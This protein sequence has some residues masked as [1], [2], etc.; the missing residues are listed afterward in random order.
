LLLRVLGSGSLVGRAADWGLHLAE[1]AAVAE[2]DFQ[3]L[4]AI[5]ESY[6]RPPVG[7]TEYFGDRPQVDHGAGMDLSEDFDVQFLDQFFDGLPDKGFLRRSPDSNVLF[8]GYEK[9]DLVHR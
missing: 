7:F 8:V 5:S 6:S 1:E 3:D 2:A 4:R 9:E